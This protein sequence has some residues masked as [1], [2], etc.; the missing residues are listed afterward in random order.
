MRRDEHGEAMVMSTAPALGSESMRSVYR[1][2]LRFG[3]RSRSELSTRL[4]LSAPTVTRV[5]RELLEGGHVH[6]LESVAQAKGRPQEPLDIEENDGPRFIGV[7][8]TADGVHAVV[9]TVRGNTLEEL[10]LPLVDPSPATVE[11][12]IVDPVSAMLGAHP[13]VAGIG[14]SLGGR[15]AGRRRVI[16]SGQLGWDAPHDLAARLETRLQ[17]PVV[18]E[19][20]LV[21]MAN[22]LQWFGIGRAYRS[23]AVL[24]V[25]AGVAIGSVVEDRVI[26]GR[27]HLAGVTELLP[28][29][30]GPD[31]GP[32]TLGEAART[33]QLLDRARRAGTLGAGEGL[34]RLREL[35]AAGDPAACAIAQDVTVALGRAAAAVVA[36]LDPEAIVLGGETVDLVRSAQPS[37]EA[38]LR[39]AVAPAQR[40]LVV[41]E[42]SG[43][44]DEWARGAAVIAIQEYVGR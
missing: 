2:L 16:S 20:D 7:K 5:T 15:V 36:L 25:G 13:R 28:V 44:F 32:R 33:D 42:L 18:V 41:R 10:V 1:D 17:R 3:P 26:E 31:G 4:G 23:F 29:G 14:V 43:D 27:T 34:E 22:G 37:L 21:A 39:E 12:T 38:L 35:L 24:T 6:L 40:A 8:V 30:P 9:T 11:E 19:N